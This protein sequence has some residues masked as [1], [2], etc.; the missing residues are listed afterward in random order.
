MFTRVKATYILL[1]YEKMQLFKKS[2][3]IKRL[4]NNR[5]NIHY[6]VKLLLTLLEFELKLEQ[7][8]RQLQN[9]QSRIFAKLLE[10]NSFKKIFFRYL[11]IYLVNIFA[12]AVIVVEALS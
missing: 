11:F 12:L 8:H 10:C 6:G 2:H 1:V 3:L 4:L 7:F 5:K 9:M